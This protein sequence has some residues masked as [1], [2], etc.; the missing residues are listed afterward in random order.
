MRVEQPEGQRGS[1]KWIQRAVAEQWPTLEQPLLH[2]SGA[3]HVTWL[4]PLK[5]D[6]FAEYR[7]ASFLR[8]LDLNHLVPELAGFWPKRGP[9]WDALGKLDSNGVVLVEAKAHIAEF[10]TP[11]TAAREESRRLIE[12]RLAGCAE[13]LGAKSRASWADT[14]YQFGNRLAHLW[15]LR[16]SGVEAYLLLVGFLDDEGMGGPHSSETWKAAYQ[17]ASHALGLPTN[18]RLSRYIVH[19]H[20]RVPRG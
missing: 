4:S 19:S 15:F 9:Q 13:Y 5:S 6:S 11:G 16:N 3:A 17:V 7:D 20:P 18:H 14:F 8:L 2:K 1:L 12:S 10:C